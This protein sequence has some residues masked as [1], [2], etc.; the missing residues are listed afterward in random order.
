MNTRHLIP[1]SPIKSPLNMIISTWICGALD[2]LDFLLGFCID[3]AAGRRPP[4]F[5][6]RFGM[7]GV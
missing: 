4:G 2:F 1:L 6:K 3:Q 5:L 7:D